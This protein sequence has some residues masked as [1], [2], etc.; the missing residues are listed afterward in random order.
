MS[1]VALFHHSSTSS[2]PPPRSLKDLHKNNIVIKLTFPEI[3]VLG[4]E[5]IGKSSVLERIIGL[6][7]LP[8][9]S[10]LV[11]R[12]AIRIRLV[13]L[14]DDALWRFCA[15]EGKVPDPSGYYVRVRVL[16]AGSGEEVGG[17][18]MATAWE[19][20]VHAR[21]F[22]RG[23][24][25]GSDGTADRILMVMNKIVGGGDHRKVDDKHILQ[26]EVCSP[27]ITS[28]LTLLDLPGVVGSSLGE[29]D[30]MP[31]STRRLVLK[32]LQGRDTLV[33]VVAPAQVRPPQLAPS[34]F[35]CSSSLFLSLAREEKHLTDI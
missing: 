27:K 32:Y 26:L 3:I 28:D 23:G 16:D 5:S 30:D 21:D 2:P 14:S 9:G 35:I 19:G 8:R 7:L 18:G 31:A 20:P 29:Q 10:G 12:M 22:Y 1:L 24:A 25:E 33:L 17:A 11:T 6:P 34:F 4:Q 15:A 13:H